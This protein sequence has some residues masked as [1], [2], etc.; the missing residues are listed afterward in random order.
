MNAQPHDLTAFE[1][2][3]HVLPLGYITDSH[4]QVEGVITTSHVQTIGDY[5]GGTRRGFIL[6]NDQAGLLHSIRADTVQRR[7]APP[8]RQLLV[9]MAA[10]QLVALLPAGNTLASL[11]VIPVMRKDVVVERDLGDDGWMLR[12]SDGFAFDV[13]DVEYRFI[14]AFDGE[15]SLAEIAEQVRASVLEDLFGSHADILAIEHASVHAI[16]LQLTDIALKL[17]AML[18]A[19][20]I[21]TLEPPA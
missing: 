20:E 8:E 14:S 5:D 16:D 17:V 21:T 10:Q 6:D 9:D 1:Q 15:L 3:V 4:E 18:R 2:P 11:D 13:H 7:V 19:A 12:A